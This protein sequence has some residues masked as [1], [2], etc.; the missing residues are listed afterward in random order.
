MQLQSLIDQR[1]EKYPTDKDTSHS[2]IEVYDDVWNYAITTYGQKPFDVLEIGNNGGGS[3]KLWQDYILENVV[4]FTPSDPEFSIDG[5]ELLE[6]DFLHELNKVDEV[7]IRMNTDAYTDE[8]VKSLGDKKYDI[9]ID[10]GSHQPHHQLFAINKYFSLLK[11]Q[12][13]MVVEDVQSLQALSAVL[14]YAEL[15]SDA[16]LIVHDR[17]HIKNR[18]DDI[19]IVIYKGK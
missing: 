5:L 1:P 8:T 4:S 15:P 16:R 14:L 11:P 6:N 17:R 19:M 9:I 7:N 3:I 18:Y 10:D 2:Y 12:G 13:V